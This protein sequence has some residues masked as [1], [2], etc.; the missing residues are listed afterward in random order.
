MSSRL[1]TKELEILLHL[2]YRGALN[3]IIKATTTSLAESLGIPQQT[4]SNAL[5][6][7]EE[8]SL[9]S[10]DGR[11]VKVTE[12]GEKSLRE[13]Y[14]DCRT[15]L[16]EGESVAMK[17]EVVSGVGDGKYY[18]QL[19]PYRRQFRKRLGYEPYP[20][21]LNVSLEDPEDIELKKNLDFSEGIGIEGFKSNGRTLGLVRCY[22]CKVRR[23]GKGI[24]G[25][26]IMPERSHYGPDVVEIVSPVYLRDKLNLEDGDEV[27]V[28]CNS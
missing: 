24:E 16:R 26:V 22:P 17:G 27:T 8:D 6:R 9:V 19:E 4:V 15:S 18:M 7:L 14:R 10:R 5:R 21:T 3:K 20:G 2:A 11:R 13:L 12:K 23:K 28:E 1:R 25:A